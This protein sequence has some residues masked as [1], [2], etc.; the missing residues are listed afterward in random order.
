MAAF[1]EPPSLFFRRFHPV[2]RASCSFFASLA[3]MPVVALIHC[4]IFSLR[5]DECCLNHN[6]KLVTDK[7]ILCVAVARP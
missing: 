4:F 5:S 2:L 7:G 1:F 6:T 3:F